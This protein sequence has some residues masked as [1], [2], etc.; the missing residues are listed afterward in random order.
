MLARFV[1]SSA[2][3]ATV[4]WFLARGSPGRLVIEQRP[5]VGAIVSMIVYAEYAAVFGEP[6][7][8]VW[9]LIAAVSVGAC[10]GWFIVIAC[11]I[12]DELFRCDASDA[13]TVHVSDPLDRRLWYVLLPFFAVV[14]LGRAVWFFATLI[15]R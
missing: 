7:S 2:A 5:I 12:G 9:S 6:T 3:A 1:L 8:R 4:A 15:R 13:P 11:R 10:A 14:V